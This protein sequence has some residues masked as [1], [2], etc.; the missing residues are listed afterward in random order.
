MSVPW[1]GLVLQKVNFAQIASRLHNLIRKGYP[2]FGQENA[3]PHTSRSP[4][5]GIS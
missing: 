3:T 5:I 2:L 4:C 1:T